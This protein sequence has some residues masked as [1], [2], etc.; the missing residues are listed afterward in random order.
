[1]SRSSGY[2]VTVCTVT[3]HPLNQ[4]VCVPLERNESDEVEYKW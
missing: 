1:M 4:V 2:I 3:R